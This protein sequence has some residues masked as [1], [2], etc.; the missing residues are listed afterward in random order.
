MPPDDR[1]EQ[2]IR[3]GRRTMRGLAVAAAVALAVVAAVWAF[4]G[5]GPDTS[6]EDADQVD[7]IH[8]ACHPADGRPLPS[9]HGLD[10]EQ[11]GN[12]ARIVATGTELGVPV[13]GQVIAVATALQE[14]SLRVLLHGDSAGPDSRGLFQQR[15][16]WG[17]LEVRLDPEGSARLFYEQ[18]VQVPDW[19]TLPLTQ[20]AQAVQ[21]SAHPDHYAKWESTA[22]AV[23]SAVTGVVCA[24]DTTP[25]SAPG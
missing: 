6:D 16:P 24:P 20:A 19:W 9:V 3:P 17:P 18:L 2:D 1:Q 8:I 10:S 13:R 15:D 5:T 23:V 11:V 4:S 22:K 14:S 25:S 7:S 21:N 12:A